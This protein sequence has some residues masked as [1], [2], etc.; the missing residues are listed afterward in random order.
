MVVVWFF[1]EYEVC[2]MTGNGNPVKFV[3]K[4]HEI[5]TIELIFGRIQLFGTAVRRNLNHLHFCQPMTSQLLNFSWS[6]VLWL[7]ESSLDGWKYHRTLVHWSYETNIDSLG[8][9]Y[10]CV[11]RLSS[12]PAC[13][14]SPVLPFQ[15]NKQWEFHFFLLKHRLL[16]MLFFLVKLR[17]E[18]K[19][20][21]IMTTNA[22]WFHEFF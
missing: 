6:S 5:T 16:C 8:F 7:V 13:C 19:M 2:V 1:F 17:G 18:G 3:R 21:S 14:P 15:L 9:K 10:F 11:A 12:P 20:R 4:I 22:M